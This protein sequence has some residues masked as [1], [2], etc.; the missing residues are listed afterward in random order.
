MEVSAWVRGAIVMVLLCVAPAWAESNA[1]RRLRILEET[2]R[3]QQD[4]IRQL[5]QELQTQQ[6]APAAAAKPA[7]SPPTETAKAESKGFQP[8]KWLE[9]IALFGDT[10]IRYEGFFNRPVKEGG[11][12]HGRSRERY[13]ARFGLKYTYSD[14]LSATIRL[15]SGNP[16]DPIST[17]QTFTGDFSRK[18][19]NLDWA[20]ITVSPGQTFGLRPGM[21]NVTGGKFPNPMFRVGEMVFD[22]DLSPEGFG[23]TFNVLGK[24]WGN[25]DQVRVHVQQWSFNEV[26]NIQDGWMFGGQVNPVGHAGPFELE[27]GIA[28]YWWLN[29]DQIAQALNTNSSLINTNMVTSVDDDGDTEITGYVGAFNQTNVTLAAT[30][31]DAVWGMPLRFF[32]DF[33]HNWQGAGSHVNGVQVGAKFGQTKVRGDWAVTGLY[34]YEGQ[35]AAVSSFVWSDFGNGG[36][37]QQGPVLSFDYQLFDPLTLTARTY[38]TNTIQTPAET[39][40]PTQLRLQL[41]AQ[42]KF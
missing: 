18:N 22:D 29:P 16:N 37:N 25:L 27:G 41:D 10:R 36:T 19:I 39:S 40:N 34:E 33:V 13:R 24:P 1:E 26:D 14:E 3:Q 17:N 35:E 2:V 21:I 38:F 28:Q 15:A 12:A 20:F 5:R 7:E 11:V 9:K 31:P 30:L 32:G 4:E 8:P 23:E 42:V 6:T